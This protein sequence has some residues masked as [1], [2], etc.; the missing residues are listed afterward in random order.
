MGLLRGF[1][2]GQGG[3][4]LVTTLVVG[5]VGIMTTTA[6]VGVV[7]MNIRVEKKGHGEE[8]S[9]YT[10]TGAIEAVLADVAIGKDILAPDYVLP[11]V[12]LNHQ[13]PRLAVSDPSAFSR[14]KTQPR[15]LDPWADSDTRTLAPKQAFDL[16]LNRPQPWSLLVINWAVSWDPP[17]E[18]KVDI[19]I[20]VY[21]EELGKELKKVVEIEVDLDKHKVQDSSGVL[22]ARVRLGQSSQYRIRFYN[23]GNTTI[24]TNPF[25]SKGEKDR[26]WMLATGSPEAAG[27]SKL[28]IVT[29]TVGDFQL[30]S[31]VQQIPAPGLGPLR[32]NRT[33]VVESWSPFYKLGALATP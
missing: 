18:H 25:S 14:P 21:D 10:A 4:L 29:A 7:Q 28:Y 2:R 9:Y 6:M 12:T 24:T 1:L 16:V 33:V 20:D 23:G 11:Q 8:I 31:L 17:E 15:Y 22:M 3:Q 5:T 30:R 26:T 13:E 32:L 27:F 19:D